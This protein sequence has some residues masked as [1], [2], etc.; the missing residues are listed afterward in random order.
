MKLPR[1]PKLLLTLAL[2]TLGVGGII[3]F[4]GCGAPPISGRLNVDE[5]RSQ[6]LMALAADDAGL[7]ADP[8]MRLSRQ[9][10]LADLQINRGWNDDARNTLAAAR[11]TLS[12]PEASKLNDHARLSG[13]VSTSELCRRIHDM[14]GAATATDAALQALDRIE[15]PGK[16]CQY[17][18]GLSNE[19]Q[20]IKGK[21]AAAEL[22]AKSGP[23]TKSIDSIPLRR[24]ALV[25]FATA[26]FNLDDFTAGQTMLRQEPDPAWRSDVLAGMAQ[27]DAAQFRPA[28]L[29]TLRH[30]SAAASEAL[31]PADASLMPSTQPFFG[32][33]LNYDQ[34][35]KN[36]KKSQTTKD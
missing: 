30:S 24:Q 1:K 29:M 18:M 13:W 7:I 21:P 3:H 19:L 12:S 32:R 36:Q 8:D 25:A 14:P 4:A 34:V 26:L 20:Y 33:Q 5:N 6:K 15:D 2:L 35:F 10:N 17:V 16:R 23:W 31:A 28:E 22:L 9:L 27:S 11:K